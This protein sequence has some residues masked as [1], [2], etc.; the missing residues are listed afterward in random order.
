MT[1]D[2]FG[3]SILASVI[4]AI[5]VGSSIVYKIINKNKTKKNIKQKGKK[6]TAIM[7]STININSDRK[8][9]G[10]KTK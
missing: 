2:A 8:N 3:L 5:I 4:A 10:G 6:N 9:G 7:D 1:L